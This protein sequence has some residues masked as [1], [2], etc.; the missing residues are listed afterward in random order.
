MEITGIATANHKYG[1]RGWDV[2]AHERAESRVPLVPI[3]GTTF[4]RVPAV[5]VE[6]VAIVVRV[7]AR[8][9]PVHTS[10]IFPA[11]VSTPVRS[12]GGG[13]WRIVG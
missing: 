8:H 3:K 9:V 5:P 11:T 12:D 2:L 13:G 6:G 4:L 10:L 7:A 1:T